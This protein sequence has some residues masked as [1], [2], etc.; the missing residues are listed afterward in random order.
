MRV[1]RA[2]AINE[3]SILLAGII[4]AVIAMQVYIRR[5]LQARYRDV[6]V[7]TTAQASSSSINQ[8]EPHSFDSIDTISQDK[9]MDVTIT[10]N[11]RQRTDINFSDSTRDGT[12][13]QGIDCYAD[14]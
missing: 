5:G 11:G 9:N 10:G 12:K 14:P 7:A 1:R 6:V 4:L 2:Q 3:Y 8:Y 13:I